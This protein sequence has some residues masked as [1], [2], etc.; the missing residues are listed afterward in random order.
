MRRFE[1]LIWIP[2]L[3]EGMRDT[4]P[5]SLTPIFLVAYSRNEILPES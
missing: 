3:K 1:P 5:F 4:P 2:R